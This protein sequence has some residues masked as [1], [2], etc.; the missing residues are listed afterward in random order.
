MYSCPYNSCADINLFPCVCRDGLW[1][2]SRNSFRGIVMISMTLLLP[3][4]W[5]DGNLPEALLILDTTE[6]PLIRWSILMS[7]GGRTRDDET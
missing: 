4:L 1:R 3:R 2:T 6:M 7:S 5:I